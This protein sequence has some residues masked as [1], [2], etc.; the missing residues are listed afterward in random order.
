MS[1]PQPRRCLKTYIWCR[2]DNRRLRAPYIAETVV[3]KW[4]KPGAQSARQK[5]G[6]GI[7]S[8]DNGHRNPQSG[9]QRATNKARAQ[10]LFAHSTLY[11]RRRPHLHMY[12]TS[13]GLASDFTFHISPDELLVTSHIVHRKRIYTPV[14]TG[15]VTLF[16]CLLASQ[17]PAPRTRGG[18]FLS[19]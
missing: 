6:Q 9:R 19:V 17:S 18:S 5:G 8:D 13:G 16:V 2:F 10:Q 14:R 15:S 3:S 11:R 1:K 4:H 12:T 7:R